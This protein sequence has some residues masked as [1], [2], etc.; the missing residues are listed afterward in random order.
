MRSKTIYKYVLIAISFVFIQC[1]TQLTEKYI[2]KQNNQTMERLNISDFKKIKEINTEEKQVSGGFSESLGDLKFYFSYYEK[3]KTTGKEIN[4]SG[5]KKTGYRKEITY[6]NSPY[7]EKLDFY[8][9]GNLRH[10]VTGY[11]GNLRKEKD[12][13]LRRPTF[14]LAPFPVGKGYKYNEKGDIIEEIDHDKGYIIS[15][16]DLEKILLDKKGVVLNRDVTTIEKRTHKQTT[17]W[18]GEL[19][20]WESEHSGYWY[21]KY[22][23]PDDIAYAIIVSGETG[24]ILREGEAIGVEK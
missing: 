10:Q 2:N 15:I 9:N 12:G 14:S 5:N 1:K 20:D 24:D 6:R 13:V 8:P 11:I 7:K 23:K 22:Q 19:K 16:E 17:E 4:I 3:D 18:L 21:I